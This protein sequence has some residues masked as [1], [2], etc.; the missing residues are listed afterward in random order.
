VLYR[1]DEC[2]G[3]AVIAGTDAPVDFA[4]APTPTKTRSA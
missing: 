4:S 1:G 2:L 3:G